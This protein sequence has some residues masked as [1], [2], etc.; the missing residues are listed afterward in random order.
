MTA[1]ERWASEQLDALRADRFGPW[2]WTRLLAASLQRASDTRRARTRLA[3]QARA[4]SLLGMCGGVAVCAWMP[5]AGLSAPR[6]WRFALWWLATSAMLDW[7]LG[8]VEGPTGEA[9]ERLGAADGLTLLRLWSVPLLAAQDD[10]ATRSRPMFTALIASAAASD[11]L[12]GA[13]ARRTG[14]TRLGSDLDKAADAL[15]LA[16][17]ARAARRAGWL[18]P[19]V[20]RVLTIKGVLPSV[21]VAATYFRTGR[22]PAIDTFGASRRLAPALLGGLAAAPYWPRSGAALAS[23]ASIASLAIDSNRARPSSRNATADG[24]ARAATAT[25]IAAAD[26]R[27]THEPN[28]ACAHRLCVSAPRVGPCHCP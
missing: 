14:P 21:A 5:R 3:R 16:A 7:H 26:C 24:R 15:T 6:P 4:W 28:R 11:A 18:A 27:A 10:P 8:M 9:R 23:A 17:A 13:L 1:G 2:A 12:D 19:D 22:R 20:A 25:P